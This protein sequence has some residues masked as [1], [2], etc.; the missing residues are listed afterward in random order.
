MKKENKRLARPYLRA[1]YQGNRL[2]GVATV[3]ALTLVNAADVFVAVLLQLLMD[4]S[5]GQSSLGLV[6]L[7]WYS[8]GYLV[9][10]VLFHLLLRETRNRF[11]RRMNRQYKAKIFADLTK[12]NISAFASERTSTYISILTHDAAAVEQDY[13]V[14]LISIVQLTLY[15]ILGLGMMLWYS[16]SLTLA[17][18]VLSVLPMALS[19]CLGGS[20]SRQEKAVSDRNESFVA[21]VK[22]LLTGFPVI[23]SFQAEAEAETLYAGKNAALEEAK[24]RRRRTSHAIEIVSGMASIVMQLG[25]FILGAYYAMQGRITGG[26]VLAFVQ[27]MNC[28]LSP[29]QQLPQFLASRKAARGLIEKTAAALSDNT[30]PEGGAQVESLGQGIVCRDL[31]FGY[32]EEH[33]ILRGLDLRFLPGKSYAI[34][35]ASGSGKS[36]LLNLLLGS[37]SGYRGSVTIGGRELREISGDSL[38]NILSIIQQSVFVFDSTIEENITMFKSFPEEAIQ[39]AIRR[40]GL[41]KLLEEKGRDYRCGENGCNLSGGERQRISIARCLLKN[42]QVLLMDEATAALDAETAANVTHAILDIRG[43]TRII[44]THKLDEAILNRFDEILVLRN[45]AIAE[46]GTFRELLAR[47]GYFHALYYVGGDAC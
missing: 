29:I 4:V 3:L 15:L 12:K 33:D 24:Y 5:T 27:L 13:F 2:L 19:I 7:L 43:L 11:V 39:D 37:W 46:R 14:N 38:Y 40:S 9:A 10:Y 20:L 45:G 34:V 42:T 35:G 26:V 6:T 8:L 44:V 41:E 23:K 22:D 47:D 25:I 17:S 32:E 36:T 28:I 30:R 31:R 1:A 16:W 18:V 21:T